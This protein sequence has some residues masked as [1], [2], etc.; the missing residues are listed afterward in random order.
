MKIPSFF[1]RHLKVLLCLLPLLGVGCGFSPEGIQ[2]RI[3]PKALTLAESFR[4]WVIQDK[5]KNGTNVTCLGYLQRTIPFDAEQFATDQTQD[6]NFNAEQQ[7]LTLKKLSLGKRLFMV[8]GFAKDTKNPV[9]LGCTEGE[10][11][12]GQKLFLSI[13]LTQLP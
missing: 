13:F 12:D 1:S 9:A 6:I 5:L 8:A 3:D 7:E 11:K 4:I 2:L 10:V